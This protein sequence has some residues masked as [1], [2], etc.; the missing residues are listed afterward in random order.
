MDHLIAV[1]RGGSDASWN[2][3]T[4]C[5][6]CNRAKASRPFVTLPETWRMRA[7]AAVAGVQLRLIDSVGGARFGG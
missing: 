5:E 1:A 2:L 6:D 3:V 4:A 7:L